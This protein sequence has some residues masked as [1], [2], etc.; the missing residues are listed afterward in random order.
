MQ[1]FRKVDPDRWEF[2]NE[3]FLGGQKHLLKT[4]KRRRHVP[5]NL[6]QE[7]GRGACVELGQYGLE[8]E[9]ERL[10]RDRTM[11]MS[12]IVKLKQQ[13]QQSRDILS[14]VEERLES[15]ERKQQQMMTFLAKLLKNPSY[16]QQFAQRNTQKGIEIGTKRRLTA[17]PSLES[18][19][20]QVIAVLPSS[21]SPV[22][23]YTTRD[24]VELASIETD[25]QSLFSSVLDNSS[26]SEVGNPPAAS[27]YKTAGVDICNTVS[28]TLWED[29]LKEDL[30]TGD[31][32]EIVIGDQSEADVEVEDLVANPTDWGDDLQDIVDDMGYLKPKQ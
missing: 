32:E 24:G 27:L 3:G 13:H 22:V 31:P 7:G 20:E 29:L 17:S 2:A 5:P 30:I 14:D 8:G 1:G 12:E 15:T 9:L 18:L 16:A 25:M 23:D 19:Q 21:V 11:L 28:E 6:E 4:I 26:S 10:T